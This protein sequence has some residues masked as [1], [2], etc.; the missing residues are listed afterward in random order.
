MLWIA[1]LFWMNTFTSAQVMDARPFEPYVK[2]FIE[3]SDGLF[4]EEDLRDQQIEMSST[5]AKDSKAP[6]AVGVCWWGTGNKIQLDTTYWYES[7][8][9]RMALVFHEI[10]HC[11]CGLDH[12]ATKGL[13][14]LKI[15]NNF[16]VRTTHGPYLEDGCPRS[17]MYPEVVSRYCVD[18]H[19]KHYMDDLFGQCRRKK[20][21]DAV[22]EMIR[23]TNYLRP[24]NR[25]EK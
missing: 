20:Q 25:C 10:G 8:Q 22:M 3:L 16:G 9:N 24:P 11:T 1:T 18:R 23:R 2:Q 15:L 19:F 17:L 5:V 13:F 6:N 14:I 12:P 21:V 4:V 7:P